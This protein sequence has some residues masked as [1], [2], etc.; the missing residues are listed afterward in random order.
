[1]AADVCLDKG[2]FAKTLE[3]LDLPRPKSFL[4]GS[5]RLPDWSKLTGYFL[6][7][8]DSYAF[9][10]RFGRK[11]FRFQTAADA[12]RIMQSCEAAGLEVLVQEFIPGPHTA[13]HFLDGFIDRHGKLCALFAR[14]RNR[15]Q[16]GELSN[17]SCLTSIAPEIMSDAARN[18][19]RLLRTI[20]YRGIFSAEFKLDARDGQ[21]K[22]IEVNTRVWGDLGLALRCGV[23]VVEMAYRDALGKD[24]EPVREYKVGQQWISP[25][26]D[27]VVGLEMIRAGELTWGAFLRSWAGACFDTLCLDDPLP[28]LFAVRQ[29]IQQRLGG[30]RMRRAPRHA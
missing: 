18:L 4:P 20:G 11:A 23:D 29:R 6:K 2:E 17:S 27:R 30:E 25:F 16:F 14:R 28:A 24:V 12:G 22:F 8:R 26:R 19:E 21:L 13:H 1:M 3:R 9:S 10:L 7:P 5:D 15:A